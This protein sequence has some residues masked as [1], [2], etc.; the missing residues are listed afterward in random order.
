MCVYNC[1]RC[2]DDT[3]KR[4]TGDGLGLHVVFC[5][6][7]EIKPQASHG[8]QHGEWG[9][10]RERHGM[11]LQALMPTLSSRR[12]KLSGCFQGQQPGRGQTPRWKK[13]QHMRD[14]SW[15]EMTPIVT[16]KPRSYSF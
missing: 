8:M 13:L 6:R 15:V 2:T 11:G 7:L 14:S 10:G 3:P 16:V 9:E 4:F 1:K 5:N 12:L